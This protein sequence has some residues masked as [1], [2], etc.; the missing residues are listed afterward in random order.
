MLK[1]WKNRRKTIIFAVLGF[2]SLAGYFFWC[3]RVYGLGYPLDDAWI[4][5]TYA[6]NFAQTGQWTFSPG[7]TSGGSTGP[8][9]GLLLAI[10]HLVQLPEVVGTAFLGW[11]LLFLTAVYTVKLVWVIEPE[12]TISRIFV[13]GIILFEWHL[14]WSAGSGMETLLFGLLALIVIIRINDLV[15]EVWLTGLIAGISVWVRPGG[16]TLIAPVLFVLAFSDIDQKWNKIAQALIGF[17]VPIIPYFLFNFF[18]IG[19]IWPNT[20][21]AKQAEYVELTKQPLLDRFWTV[22]YQL[23]VGVGLLVLPGFIRNMYLAI[24]DRDWCSMGA[25]CWV[26]GYI[27][28]YAFKLPV[29]YQHGRYVM[30]V[31]PIF[32][33]FGI[34]GSADLLLWNSDETWRRIAGRVLWVSVG[35]TGFAFWLQGANAF[36]TDVA[37]IETEMVA[38]AKWI[39]QNLD[40]HA[41]VA[42]HDIG[43]LGYFGNRQIVDLAGLISPDVIPIIRDEKAL[44]DYLTEQDVDYLMTFPDWYRTLDKHQSVVYQTDGKFAPKFGSGN[45]TVY[46]WG[47][48]NE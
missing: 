37:V 11:F 7:K 38:A 6:R 8:L 47:T 4:H 16:L 13:G 43:A 28:I 27:S 22:G 12:I 29:D 1:P 23:L 19:D 25:L 32:I 3:S 30:P 20:F 17:L 48:D 45:M 36:A 21:F 34:A 46:R 24:K 31:L 2:L 10:L 41:V 42:A 39:D 5:Q 40:D 44:A 35:L 9:W 26:V 15:R 18:I 33:G 14:V